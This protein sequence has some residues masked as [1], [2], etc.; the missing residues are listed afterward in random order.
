MSTNSQTALKLELDQVTKVL[1]A[2]NI[3]VILLLT[4]VDC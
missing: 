3:H 2:I 4:N 1:R